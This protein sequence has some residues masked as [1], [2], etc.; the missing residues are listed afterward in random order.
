MTTQTFRIL[1]RRTQKVDAIAKVTGRAQF[2]ADVSQPRMLVGKVL[3]SPHAHA[4]IRRIDTRA[5][6]ALPG[7]L[8][9][10][11]GQDLPTLTPGTRGAS[12]DVTV[13]AYYRSQEVL[14][15]D[16]VLYHGHAVA[17]VAATSSDIA[18]DALDRIQ[19]EYDTLPHV[20]EPVAAM[21][22][23]AVLLHEALYTQT[24]TGIAAT[25]SNVAEHL[26]MGRGNVE[27]GFAAADVVVE[28][29]FRTQVVHQGY[30]E[31]DSE[32]AQVQE[33]GSVIV[34]ANTQTTYAQRHALAMLL[35]I[36]LH[37]IRV[38]PTEVGGAFGGKESV[39]MS[40]LCVALSRQA[41]LPVRLTLS[42]EEVLRAT[43]PGCAMVSTVKIGAR[44]DGTITA[45]QA[46]LVYDA[47]AFP[48]APL[49]SAVRRVFSH[50]RTPH[51]RIDAYDVVTNKPHVAAYRAPGATPTNF[52]VA[53]VIDEVSEALS[54]EPLAF[55]LKNVSRPGDPMPDG[56]Q[57]PSVSLANVLRRVQQHPCWTTPLSGPQQG[58]GIAVGLWTLPGGTTS[59]HITLSADGSVTLVLGT[60]DLSATRTSLAMIAA[61]ALGLELDEVR[62]VVGD[63]DMVAYSDPSAGDRVTYITSKAVYKASQDLLH[64]LR[65]RVAQAF[66]VS[67]PDI[68]YECKRFWV[69][70]EPQKAVTLAEVARRSVSGES[71]VMGYGSVSE[72]F[73]TVAIAPNAAVHVA[74]VEV[75]RH[76]GQVTLLKYTTFQDVG[77]CVNP[78]QVA[79]QM[80]GGAT[81][82]IG[83][84]LSEGLDFDPM[85]VVQ[86]ASF[87]DCRLP[88]SLDVPG[89]DANIIEVPSGDHPYGIRS[90]GQV[91]MVPPAGAIANAIYWATGVR[92]CELPIV[93]E[94][95]YWALQNA[96]HSITT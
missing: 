34:W 21:Q 17:A 22:P 35:D 56:V 54:L 90:V 31:P 49:R 45:I 73:D 7:A 2:G 32:A 3:R 30:I 44:K 62:V 15:R 4:R 77:L 88:S 81:Q 72:T 55:H 50:Y 67:P 59:C 78:D 28:R 43:G 41:G 20:L 10:I 83:W 25:P 75:D 37:Q 18:E 47:G 82:G 64:N 53:S 38:I 26:E 65:V 11:T 6:R 19:V 48:G 74:D 16:K 87:L 23:Q 92:V 84:A 58:R 13:N 68:L 1:G 79:G 40:A 91:P 71:A 86:N 63:T 94:R 8:A 89:I 52:A 39:R 36:P 12:G 60:V 51:L 33:D 24:A 61:E 42:R 93:P 14:A 46:R 70:E 57:L 5:A 76:T 9:V 95:L 27:T 96:K 80:Q 29:T 85:G 66:D 69:R